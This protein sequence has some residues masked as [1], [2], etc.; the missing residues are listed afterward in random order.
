MLKLVLTLVILAKTTC[1]GQ[2]LPIDTV[3]PFNIILRI[4]SLQ[5]ANVNCGSIIIWKHGH[6]ETDFYNE[7]FLDTL[8]QQIFKCD[9]VE[10]TKDPNDTILRKTSFYLDSN[11]FV[12][13][14]F[15]EYRNS[16]LIISQRNYL[17]TEDGEVKNVYPTPMSKNILDDDIKYR[18]KDV[19]FMIEPL[20]RHLRSKYGG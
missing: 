6:N 3:S 1:Y 5:K 12:A 18:A 9:Y 14:V 10:L 4:D 11:H 17:V 2:K 19:W 8:S 15:R 16:Q 7:F 13:V 20:K